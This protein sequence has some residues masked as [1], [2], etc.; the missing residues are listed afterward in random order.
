[1]PDTKEG[2]DM[3][4]GWVRRKVVTLCT[5]LRGS[6]RKTLSHLVV[7][8]MRCRRASLADIGRAMCTGTVAKHNIKRVWRFVSNAGVQVV[9]GAR[10]LVVL[11]AKAAGGRLFVA[12]DWV[13]IGPYKVL[14]AAVPLRGRSVPVLFAAYEKWKLYKSQNTFEEG[15]FIVLKA[16]LPRGCEVVVLAD[17][18]F[19]RAALARRLQ[20]LGLGYVIRVTGNVTFFSERYHG[21]LYELHMK[22]GHRRDLGFGQYCRSRP[23]TQRVLAYWGRN[24]SAPWLLATDLTW[25][26]KKIVAAFKQR[27]MIEELFRDEKNIRYGW[28]L[29]QLKLSSGQ[30]LERMLLVLAF[31]YLFLVLLGLICRESLSAKHW[32]SAVSKKKQQCSAFAI[33]RHMQDTTTFSVAQLLLTFSVLLTQ[34]SEENWG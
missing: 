23:V 26:W 20:E 19:Q 6:Q 29:R 12:V 7:G 5:G 15:L 31:A 32:A 21:Q 24:E 13:D 9:E 11:A 3:C 27:M 28:G 18:G 14:R 30:R 4:H 33:G 16:L 8:A 34:L 22:C 2:A 10:A 1:M 17:R 25:G